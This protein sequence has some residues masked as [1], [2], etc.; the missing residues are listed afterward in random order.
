MHNYFFVSCSNFCNLS[1]IFS[2]SNINKAAQLWLVTA[3]I[4]LV[5]PPFN[6]FT[7]WDTE[8]LVDGL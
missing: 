5:F 7:S 4:N 8:S 2:I 1:I 6:L 3:C